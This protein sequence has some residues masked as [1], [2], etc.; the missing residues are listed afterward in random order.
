MN[1]LF[2]HMAKGLFFCILFLGFTNQLLAQTPQPAAKPQTPLPLPLREISGIV[3]DTTDTGIPYAT[4]RLFSDRDTLV[5][6]TNVD[7]IFV[8]KN[9]KSA[10]YTLNIN[11]IG[12]KALVGK[13]KQNDAIARIVMDPI[14]LKNQPNTLNEIVVNGTP[15]IT[16]KTD[17]VEYRAKDYIVRENA[18]VDELLKKMEGLNLMYC[19]S[20]DRTR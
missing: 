12:Y 1:N 9:V 3:K 17:T 11:S 15:S 18:T 2:R 13:Y 10:S 5:V 20:A 19:P 14:V 8:F 4:V 7:G 16:Y 6:T